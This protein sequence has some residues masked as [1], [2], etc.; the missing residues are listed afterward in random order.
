[1]VNGHEWGNVR[2]CDAQSGEGRWVPGWPSDTDKAQN[3][4]WSLGLSHKTIALYGSMSAALLT[5]LGIR[6]IK[7]SSQS[8]FRLVSP[9]YTKEPMLPKIQGTFP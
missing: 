3:L 2:L 5:W 7:P 1:M 8:L 4:T 6:Y 9:V